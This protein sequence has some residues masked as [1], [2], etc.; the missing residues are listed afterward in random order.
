MDLVWPQASV[1]LV[2]SQLVSTTQ[3]MYQEDAVL[4]IS[5]CGFIDEIPVP[6]GPFPGTPVLTDFHGT[7]P[8]EM[9]TLW[10]P[11]ISSHVLATCVLDGVACLGSGGDA[12]MP[13]ICGGGPFETIAYS[14]SEPL[15]IQ[16]GNGVVH[17]WQEG[18][19]AETLLAESYYSNA[20]VNLTEEWRIPA[21]P[22][23]ADPGTPLDPLKL[24]AVSF[25]VTDPAVESSLEVL[26]RPDGA[27]LPGLRYQDGFNAGQLDWSDLAGDCS[28]I[29][30]TANLTTPPILGDPAGTHLQVAVPPVT[31]ACGSGDMS[32]SFT[33]DTDLGVV[34][35]PD[36]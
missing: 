24:M 33:V 26:A 21:I 34:V 10:S 20:R 16:T 27:Q 23:Y 13:R 12:V 11:D 25:G 22:V 8:G 28:G 35:R 30:A 29:S 36:N 14:D 3:A 2:P 4:R 31:L 15:S 17:I 32:L 18:G 19:S 5:G 6:Y 9:H 1:E 7:Y